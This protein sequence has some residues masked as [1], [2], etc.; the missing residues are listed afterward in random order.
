MRATSRHSMVLGIAVALIAGSACGSDTG[1]SS[2]DDSPAAPTAV[3]ST[4]VAEVL[5]SAPTYNSKAFSMPFD[6]TVPTWLATEPDDEQP[7]F[8]TWKSSDVDRAVR[9]LIPVNVYPPGGTGTAPPPE[10][11]IAYL[12]SQADHGAHF[13]DTVETTVDGRPATIVTATVDESLDGSLGCPTEGMKASDCFGLQPDLVL[14]LAVI[15]TGDRPLLVW[16]RNTT[17]ATDSQT[18]EV[19]SFETMLASIRFIERA[20]Q[21]PQTTTTAVPVATPLDG[22]YRWTITKDDAV[23]YGPPN[24]APELIA[25]LPWDFTMVLD[26]GKMEL[27]RH[28]SEGDW[29]DGSGSY[30]ID[31]DQI[32][33]S[34]EAVGY[35]STYSFSVDD[36]GTVHLEAQPPINDEGEP[37]V[38]SAKPWTKIAEV[39]L[40]GTYSWTITKDDALAHGTPNDKTP[41]ALATFP[42]TFTATMTDQTWALSESS[43]GVVHDDGGGS[44]TVN[45]DRVIFDWDGN[46]LTF[47]FTLDIDGTMHLTPRPTMDPGDQFIWATEPW[48]KVG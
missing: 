29:D 7:N 24:D 28:D 20:V 35:E 48:E 9:F 18:N 16:L 36:D 27:R 39:S 1:S 45:G 34:W 8:V 4:V 26:G 13:A 3:A 23:A 30:T 37:F 17:S 43:A 14:R 25:V 42:T 32:V 6:I 41:E 46:P 33:F 21:A 5:E 10:D 31:G 11:Y 44:Y 15:D 12:L 40:T 19:E 38:L 22:T 2:P 47:T